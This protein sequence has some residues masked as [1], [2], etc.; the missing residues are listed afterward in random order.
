MQLKGLEKAEMEEG[1]GYDPLT[2]HM[3]EALESIP[4]QSG[5]GKESSSVFKVV[6]L[7]R[8]LSTGLSHWCNSLITLG[9][10]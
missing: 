10:K 2:E 8:F 5:E 7:C 4:N 3:C 6:G 9:G 1:W